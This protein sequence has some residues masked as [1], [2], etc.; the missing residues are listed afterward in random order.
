MGSG[1]PVPPL[2]LVAAAQIPN[3]V[4]VT[5]WRRSFLDI[6]GH[7]CTEG[8]SGGAAAIFVDAAGLSMRFRLK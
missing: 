3:A 2:P 5:R 1:L 4:T 7:V 6:L 8:G